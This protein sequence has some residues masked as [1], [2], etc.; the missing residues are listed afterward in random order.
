[1]KSAFG[2]DYRVISKA[3]VQLNDK[4]KAG[5]VA[6]GTALGARA[7]HWAYLTP[8]HAYNEHIHKPW[9]NYQKETA[10]EQ[11]GIPTKKSERKVFRQKSAELDVN[12]RASYDAEKAKRAKQAAA[13]PDIEGKI[14]G[15]K[16]AAEKKGKTFD[17][18]LTRQ[19]LTANVKAPEP[20][21]DF[22]L[23]PA[24]KK[25][26]ADYD[27]KGQK[28]IKPTRM[29]AEQADDFEERARTV[30]KKYRGT[31]GSHGYDPKRKIK[32][33]EKL[34]DPAYEAKIERRVKRAIVDDPSAEAATRQKLRSDS[35][36]NLDAIEHWSRSKEFFREFPKDLPGSGYRRAGGWYS[37][38]RTG[39]AV[40]VG[41]MGLG[42][43]AGYKGTKA[44]V[45]KVPEQKEPVGKR[46]KMDR[47]AFLRQFRYVKQDQ[48]N[49]K[50]WSKVARDPGVIA[51]SAIPA[52]GVVGYA[53]MRRSQ[54]RKVE[55]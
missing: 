30:P 37:K 23:T 54:K 40:A 21:P 44:L 16:A 18:A 5:V 10:K 55:L 32:H 13:G 43:Y 3:S 19:H 49:L 47:P 24:Q 42:A 1:M 27:R 48:L 15:M 7:G 45:N 34:K 36:K 35:P 8:D 28:K 52:A 14:R 26:K 17:E 38:G 39:H 20:M 51:L 4:E 25:T 22:E 53:A 2:P 6:G 50:N 11:R 12:A 9:F 29:T 46:V 41:A 31:F 33:Q